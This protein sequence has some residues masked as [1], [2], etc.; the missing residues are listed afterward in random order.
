MRYTVGKIG[1]HQVGN[2]TIEYNEDYMFVVTIT[3]KIYWNYK[4]E[5]WFGVRNKRK[6]VYKAEITEKKR[7]I[8][9]ARSQM[10][11]TISQKLQTF[12]KME[13]EGR[14]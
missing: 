7:N 2:F 10:E 12:L 3:I 6:L 9:F 5:G 8:D 1:F 14:L 13:K 4:K 11:D